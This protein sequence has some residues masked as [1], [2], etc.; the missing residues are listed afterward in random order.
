MLSAISDDAQYLDVVSEIKKISMKYD[1]DIR[2][3]NFED[4]FDRIY[5]IDR[6]ENENYIKLAIVVMFSVIMIQLCMQSTNILKSTQKYGIYFAN[7]FTKKDLYLMVVIENILR[8][9]IS[10]LITSVLTIM[11]LNHSFSMMP[12]LLARIFYEIK[13]FVVADTL[14]ISVLVVAAGT[15]LP[16]GII[17]KMK[18]AMLIKELG[19]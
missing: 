11:Y 4:V 2:C 5:E 9:L 14:A 18:P 1:A 7:G 12:D 17:A 8:L 10:L 15:L 13:T 6:E 16:M 19:D 3:G